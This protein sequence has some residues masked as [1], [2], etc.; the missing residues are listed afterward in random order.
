MAAQD[1]LQEQASRPVG[2]QVPRRLPAWAAAVLAF[3]SSAA[4]LLLEVLAARLVA[5]YIGIN[6]Q[7][8][9]AVIGIALAAIAL[10]AW[11][12]G[13]LADTR[14]PAKLIG[15]CLIAGGICT[16]LV[17]PLLRWVGGSLQATSP[18]AVIGLASL[19]IFVPCLLLSMVS[20]LVV[21]LQLSSL[22]RTGRVV[23]RLSGIGTLG[24]ILATF[25]T[26]FVLVAT[27]PSSTILLITGGIL[28]VGGLI[29]EIAFARRRAVVAA[30]FMAA[31][32]GAAVLTVVAPQPCQVESAY[33]CIRTV[34]HPE[35]A[36]VKILKLST[37][38]H[39]HVDMTD[40]GRLHMGYVQAL[41]AAADL[42]K[43]GQALDGLH[44]GGG[45]GTLP[46]NLRL[47]RPGGVQ[48]VYEIDPGL[49][50]FAKRE[51]LLRP[52]DRL[53]VE[54]GDGR[55]GLRQQATQSVDLVVEDAFGA[56]SPPWHLT[57]R[58]VALDAQRVLRPGGLYTMNIIDFP[59]SEFV[60]S[61]VRTVQG[62]FKHVVLI[63]YNEIIDT[64]SGGNVIVVASDTPIALED[65][66]RNLAARDG[67]G[68]LIVADEA[69][70]AGYTEGAGELTDDFAPV[71]Q[72]I[73]V[74]LRYW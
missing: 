47:T 66:R 50:D 10:G 34:A 21:K 65:L 61:A 56:H 24:G 29:T 71:D 58:E 41:A 52:D 15:R 18:I 9:S 44:I 63:S 55:M 51:L 59:P 73:T 26:G 39:S 57:T 62:V 48:T 11:A 19:T 60:K 38:E 70:A 23:G 16:L 36:D 13:R 64:T 6:L 37:S 54:V 17:L 20:P 5:P 8:N 35:K 31:G 45:A 46:T 72:L 4:V 40:P 7:V 68:L 53:R 27:L 22:E 42:I 12:G 33:N 2:Q 49:V 69:R 74:P 32:L 30:A 25:L 1:Q 3:G 43:P 14:D 67:S 28:V